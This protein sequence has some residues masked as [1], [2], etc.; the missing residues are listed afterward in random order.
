MSRPSNGMIAPGRN[1]S[2]GSKRGQLRLDPVR[3]LPAPS[4]ARS[5]G[6]SAG[7]RS[8]SAVRA[9]RRGAAASPWRADGGEARSA[10][11]GPARPS[12][13]ERPV[14]KMPFQVAGIDFADRPAAGRLARLVNR[15]A[16]ARNQIMPV[17]QRLAFPAQPIGAGRRAATPARRACAGSSLT[18]SCDQLLAVG[19][20]GAL[21]VRRSSSLQATL[22]GNSSP[23]SSSSSLCRQQRPQPSHSASH[24]PRSSDDK[25]FSQKAFALFM[26]KITLGPPRRPDQ[27]EDLQR[28]GND[29][30]LG[31]GRIG[32][33]AGHVPVPACSPGARPQRVRRRRLS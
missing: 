9:P 29:A 13:S 14:D 8:G 17:E 20:I 26:P 28:M 21:A 10:R 15:L 12:G 32:I 27:G 16:A 33:G 4:R 22:V 24:S 19:I 1:G 30:G 7:G 11:P 25:G 2:P 6:S 18:Q 31:E 5:R 23:V 3:L